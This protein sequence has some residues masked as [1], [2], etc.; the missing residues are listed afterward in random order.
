MAVKIN[1]GQALFSLTMTPLIDVVFNLLIFFLVV[2]RFEQEEREIALPLPSA[3]Q[4]QPMIDRPNDLF[5]NIDGEGRYFV[6]GQFLT[7]K[8]LDPVL[9]A[10]WVANPTTVSV[11]IRA[12][13]RCRWQHVVSALNAC[14]KAR[15]RQYRVATS[16]EPSG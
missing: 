15:I 14:R 5:I 8:Q 7:A 11:I 13:K 16:D 1:K 2:A 4:A 3:S 6:N 12:D 9:H 10:A